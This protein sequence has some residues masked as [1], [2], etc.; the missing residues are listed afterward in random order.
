MQKGL[1]LMSTRELER[2]A[3]IKQVA[4]Q[5]L[6]Q[7]EA[8]QQ[9]KLSKRQVIRLVKKY[10][11][12]GVSAFVSKRRGRSSNRQH[13]ELTKKAIKELV[14]RLY[15]DFGPTYAAEKLV[16]CHQLSINKE[17]LRQWMMEWSLWKA[18]RHKKVTLHQSRERRPCFGELIQID[19]S[20]HDWFEGRAPACCLL[21]F[22]DD[23]TSR[24]VGLRFEEEETT[25]G[26]FTLARD[27]L[28]KFG[29]PLALYSDKFGVFRVNHPDKEDA[30]TQFGR[31]LRE[32]DI[33]LICANSPQA[34]GRVERANG[35]LQKR[36][37]REMRLQNISS[38]EA[39]N[40][41]L[42]KFLEDY[43]RRFSVAPK[44]TQDAHRKNLPTSEALDLIFGFQYERKLSKNLELSYNNVI[45][46][47]QTLGI[48]YALR[49]A[50][51]KVHQ[52][53]KGVVTLVYKGRQ[54]DYLEHKKQKRSPDILNSKELNKHLDSVSH[55]N[56]AHAPPKGHP[57]RL[58][59]SANQAKQPRIVSLSSP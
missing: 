27:Y 42:P 31:A 53:L 39:A 24:L 13:D 56:R 40:V 12:E 50:K 48:G 9:L 19:G 46:Q 5:K 3:V 21:V 43:N 2:A 55:S 20:H 25:A 59:F 57:W 44:S 10:R 8:R 41:F 38:L 33:E 34:K 54:L 17:T 49:H 26:Y 7:E 52:D 14:H 28:E 23:A 47:V 15:A 6:T 22:I 36:L 45:Y 11:L 18:K 32:L 16:E 35:T 37:T 51:I 58:P 4:A 29:K 1:L 30:E